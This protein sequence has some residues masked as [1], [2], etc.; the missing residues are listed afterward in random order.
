MTPEADRLGAV[1]ETE[2]GPEEPP[3]REVCEA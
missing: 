3:A 2:A 1:R